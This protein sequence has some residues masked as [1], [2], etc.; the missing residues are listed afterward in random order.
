MISKT[1]LL[2][3]YLG[4]VGIQAHR[5]SMYSSYNDLPIIEFMEI[6]IIIIKL[7]IEIDIC[8]T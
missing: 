6:Y 5:L 4:D 8:Y 7:C 2:V 3:L 1:H